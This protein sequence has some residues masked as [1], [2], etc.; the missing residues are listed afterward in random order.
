VSA[1]AGQAANLGGKNCAQCDRSH[2]VV[3]SH[4]AVSPQHRGRP[5]RFPRR[6][7]VS[8]WAGRGST[9][10]LP[11]W[12]GWGGRV[13]ATLCYHEGLAGYSNHWSQR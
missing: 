7:N 10:V 8:L 13:A 12:S 2:R 11:T 5:G 3:V 4:T 6:E 1:P 9:Y